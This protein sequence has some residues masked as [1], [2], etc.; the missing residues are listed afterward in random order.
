VGKGAVG[1]ITF[2]NDLEEVSKV[3]KD[4]MSK[5]GISF[6]EEK[7]H[8]ER[9]LTKI[10]LY[11]KCG[12]TFRSWGE[13]VIIEIIKTDEGRS[14]AKARSECIVPTTLFDYGKNKKNLEKLFQEL[15][16]QLKVA[17]PVWIEEKIF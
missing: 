8:N 14:L 17:G 16:K 4:T 10:E 7:V 11:G 6:T 15:T 13:K 5:V 2:E 3:I 9:P 12:K 1:E